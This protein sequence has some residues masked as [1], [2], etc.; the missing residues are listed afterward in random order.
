[1]C[2]LCR[3]LLI[4]AGRQLGV[5][6]ALVGFR[7]AALAVSALCILLALTIAALTGTGF[8]LAL[9]AWPVV[10]ALIAALIA[11]FTG[12]DLFIFAFLAA[13]AL[14]IILLIGTAW[15]L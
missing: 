7:G 11:R 2:R 14:A 4:L 5:L 1:M 10:V 9:T 8:V 3:L 13:A 15:V 12:T 6:L